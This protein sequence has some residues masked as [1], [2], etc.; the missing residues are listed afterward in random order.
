M[1]KTNS[2]SKKEAHVCEIVEWAVM[3]DS[4]QHYTV[5]SIYSEILFEVSGFLSQEMN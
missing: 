4:F 1:E 3:T 5:F 2:A